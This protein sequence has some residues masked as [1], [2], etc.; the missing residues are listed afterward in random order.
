MNIFRKD[1]NDGLKSTIC[2]GVLKLFPKIWK[3]NSTVM[4]STNKSFYVS[5]LWPNL[6]KK[7]VIK[8]NPSSLCCRVKFL[9]INFH[10]AP[11]FVEN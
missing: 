9:V 10:L 2:F 7:T 8:L 5:F 4:V 1:E 6:L 11:V 3:K